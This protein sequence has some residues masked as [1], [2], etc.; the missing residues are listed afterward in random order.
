MTGAMS[1]VL[2]VFVEESKVHKQVLYK[3]IKLHNWKIKHFNFQF[4]QPTIQT[5]T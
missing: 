2:T 1:K 5:E 4:T 3:I